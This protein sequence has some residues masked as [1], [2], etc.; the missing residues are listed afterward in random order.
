VC[1]VFFPAYINN[2]TIYKCVSHATR[3]S[4]SRLRQSNNRRRSNCTNC[5]SASK[6]SLH[7]TLHFCTVVPSTFVSRT[8]ISVRKGGSH[9]HARFRSRNRSMER[10]PIAR[11]RNQ[12]I[13]RIMKSIYKIK[14]QRGEKCFSNFSV[15]FSPD[16]F[17]SH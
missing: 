14:N 11:S 9:L 3:F 5:T 10:V 16:F 2:F 13:F 1:P 4:F 17:Q 12:L 6:I 8:H 7:D 15:F